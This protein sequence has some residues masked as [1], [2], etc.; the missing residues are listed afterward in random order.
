MKPDITF[1]VYGV[2]RPAGSKRAFAIR[3]NGQPTGKIA[4]VDDCKES[5]DWKSTV[6]REAIAAI[7]E[8]GGTMF[9]DVPG[10]KDERG[11]WNFDLLA[12]WIRYQCVACGH[13]IADTPAERKATARNG[14]FVRMN[15]KAPRHRVS[16]HWNA[17]LPPWVSWRSIVEEFVAARAAARAGDLE[18]LKTFINETLGE[19]WDD[20]LGEID[21]YDFLEGRKR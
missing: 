11:K 12:E 18:P 3:K 16:F 1:T 10:A 2:A 21:D 20:Q 14:Q 7:E 5:R 9:L 6:A 4:V 8:T 13:L 19:P 17:L 15:P